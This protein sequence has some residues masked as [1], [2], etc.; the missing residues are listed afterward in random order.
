MHSRR[1]AALEGTLEAARFQ[2]DFKVQDEVALH[3]G[4]I[5]VFA[6]IIDR[7]AQLVFRKLDGLLGAYIPV[8]S[9]GI[10][11]TTERPLAI[12][13]FTAAHELGHFYMNHR[14]SLDDEEILQRLSFLPPA[15]DSN[16]VA[17]NAFASEFLLP[18]WLVEYH[19]RRQE[20]SI[21]NLRDPAK[22]YQ[23]S[24][25]VGISYEATCWI[26]HKHH[27]TTKVVTE[28]LLGTE[29]K[30]IKQQLLAGHSLPNWF[31]N[32]WLL[33]EKDQGSAIYGE[34]SD[35]F[36]VR[37]KEHTGSG[38]LWNLDQVSAAGFTVVSDERQPSE[39]EGEIGGAVERILM[40]RSDEP[41][42]GNID[43]VESR[44]WDHS[45]VFGRFSFAYDFRGKEHGMPRAAR[46]RFAVA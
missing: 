20:W 10:L 24:L 4:R 42:I 30:T 6:A 25:R 18:E 12:Q 13:R 28:R 16:E 40:A 33:T 41:A 32:V 17:A 8:P 3:G 36:V 46:E 37:L 44:P 21:E 7:G 38:Y 34:P 29:R 27:L 43:F 5:D 45:D 26:L 1:D 2:R 15:F 31:P 11:V 14:S 23:L 9:P 19:A 35:V 39:K 22:V